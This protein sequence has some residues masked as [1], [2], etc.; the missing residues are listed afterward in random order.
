VERNAQL[1]LN[2][3]IRV[4]APAAGSCRPISRRSLKKQMNHSSLKGG[5]VFIELMPLLAGRTVLISV[6]GMLQQSKRLC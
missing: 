3:G 5:P 6:S 4:F 2:F 1:I